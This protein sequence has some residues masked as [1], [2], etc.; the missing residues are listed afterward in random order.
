MD[1]SQSFLP[2]HGPK[3]HVRI[4]P[5]YSL[6]G[7]FDQ[8]R[9]CQSFARVSASDQSILDNHNLEIRLGLRLILPGPFPDDPILGESG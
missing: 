2:K 9:P 4:L 5:T 6:E 8:L 1:G 3:S 7:D